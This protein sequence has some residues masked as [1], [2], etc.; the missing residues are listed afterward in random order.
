MQFNASPLSLQQPDGGIHSPRHRQNEEA[1][2]LD[3]SSSVSD[4]FSSVEDMRNVSV[5]VTESSSSKEFDIQVNV[6]L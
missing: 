5:P 3:S 6:Y 1:D 2:G 4:A